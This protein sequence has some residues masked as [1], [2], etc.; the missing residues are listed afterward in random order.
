MF[1]FNVN[2][3]LKNLA[4]HMLQCIFQYITTVARFYIGH[5]PK[6]KETDGISK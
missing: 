5:N 3:Y 2:M 1:W 4:Y 6:R